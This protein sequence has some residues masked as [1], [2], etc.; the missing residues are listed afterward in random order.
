MR[1]LIIDEDPV[2][3]THL[4]RALATRPDDWELL[5]FSDPRAATKVLAAGGCDV[6]VAD[7]KA[8]L[9][10]VNLLVRV[11]KMMPATLRIGLTTATDG[12][13]DPQ[14][15]QASHRVMAKPCD[16]AELLSSIATA[17][18]LREAVGRPELRD[19]IGSI[20]SLPPSPRIYARLMAELSNP[21]SSINDIASIVSSDAAIS[22][23]ML[24]IA[25]SAAFSLQRR[26][27]DVEEAGRFLGMQRLC[28]IVLA[29]ETADSFRIRGAPL[30]FSYPKLLEHAQLTC[31]AV[32]Q[33]LGRRH[34]ATET[35]AGVALMQHTGQ[36]VLAA[37]CPE[38]LGR[39]LARVE[40]DVTCFEAE[41]A[42]LGAH[43]GTVGGALLTIWGLPLEL[44]GGVARFV[45]P[46]P[47]EEEVGPAGYV[48]VFSALA[49]QLLAERDESFRSLGPPLDHDYLER[50]GLADS[51]AGWDD[52][53]RAL[54]SRAAA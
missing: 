23:K 15:L 30:G 47:T 48:H 9:G 50:V 20:S 11:R 32:T 7:A 41:T 52:E 44:A 29:I 18:D 31:S 26:I 4:V 49:A 28:G 21:D 17:A 10:P 24:Q 8:S 27:V 12:A 53:L 54:A 22:A 38:L 51:L 39:A 5:S 42:E 46:D 6:V 16:P 25:N 2:A 37:R 43:H 35:A 33:I 3:L 40:R 34:P 14:I 1:T 13:P 45:E 19:A 36:L